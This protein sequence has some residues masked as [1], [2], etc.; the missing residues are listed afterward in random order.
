LD[1]VAVVGLR[2]PRNRVSRRAISY[3]TVRVVP[4]WS[5]LLVAEYLWL[6][7]GGP[8][9]A[10]RSAL[11]FTAVAAMVH[12]VVMPRWRYRVHR[13]ETTEE[14]VYTLAGWFNQEWRVAPISRIQT[15][16]SERGAFQRWFGLTC[17]TVTTASA[18]GPLTIDGLDR[19]VAQRL[20]EE[21]TATA[22]A[23]QGDAT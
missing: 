18:A 8:G 12:L 10:L 1:G 15:I 11:V 9:L 5:I 21:L 6:M 19:A 20:V 17:V 7:A 13:W 3:W 2:P 4:G 14:A 22:Q 23:T 16:D